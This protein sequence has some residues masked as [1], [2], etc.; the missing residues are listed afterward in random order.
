[1]LCLLQAE[2]TEGKTMEMTT[3]STS[4][5]G[6]GTSSTLSDHGEQDDP[7]AAAAATAAKKQTE[8]AQSPLSTEEKTSTPLDQD[9]EPDSD[10][11]SEKEDT[12]VKL[13]E[14]LA[15]KEDNMCKDLMESPARPDD[16]QDTNMDKTCDDKEEVTDTDME[17]NTNVDTLQKNST[18]ACKF[19]VSTADDLDEMMDI[20]TVDQVEQEAQMKEEEQNK[21][22]DVDS[23]HSPAI[24]NA[25]RVKKKKSLVSYLVIIILRF[26]CCGRKTHFFSSGLVVPLTTMH[27]TYN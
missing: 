27:R 14:D 25:G 5:V 26:L 13:K 1:M 9:G 3:Q 17:M 2:E 18:P 7:A 8:C 4:E 11:D 16:S 15:S 22:M 10:T 24:S 19:V 23:V 20:G 12:V 21:S 6:C